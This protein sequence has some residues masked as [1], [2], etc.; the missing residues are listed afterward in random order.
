M[1]RGW[2]WVVG[3]GL[4]VAALVLTWLTLFSIE[5][6]QATPFQSWAPLIQAVLSAAAIFS[7]WGLQ[8]LKRRSDRAETEGETRVAL[9]EYAYIF[10]WTLGRAVLEVRAGGFDVRNFD[11]YRPP[12]RWAIDGMSALKI[13]HLP[14]AIAVQDFVAFQHS[15]ILAI[16]MMDWVV[17]QSPKAVLPTYL[18]ESW[19]STFQN[20]S[21]LL[22]ALNAEARDPRFDPP[23]K[24]AV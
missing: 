12:M 13:A 21:D 9:L 8:T 7:A 16:T 22:A 24:R 10:E 14:N 17:L 18:D 11:L 6:F 5:R 15:S 19:R 2:S 3:T 20:R 1:A 4:Y 23:V